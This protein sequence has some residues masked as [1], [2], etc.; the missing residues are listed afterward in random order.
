MSIAETENQKKGSETL[1]VLAVVAVIV[2]ALLVLAGQRQQALRAS[3]SGMDGL[4]NWLRSEDLD[5][6][7]FSGGWTY[8]RRDNRPERGAGL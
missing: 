8:R 2:V 5:A 1:L 6:Q 7:A 3:P 4:V